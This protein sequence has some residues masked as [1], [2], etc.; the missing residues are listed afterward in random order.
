MGCWSTWENESPSACCI[1]DDAANNECYLFDSNICADLG[2]T[3]YQGQI[4]S[5]TEC[6]IGTTN[7][8]QACCIPFGNPDNEYQTYECVSLTDDDCTQYGGT[9][10]GI[11]TCQ[12]D[13]CE[14]FEENYEA[15]I[16]EP[17]DSL[18]QGACCYSGDAGCGVLSELECLSVDGN[19][20]MGD[21]VAC[22]DVACDD[23]T[24]GGGGDDDGDG[25][26]GS[27]DD[28]DDSDDDNGD[29]SA[30]GIGACC[31]WEEAR[32]GQWTWGCYEYTQPECWE[33][34]GIYKGDDTTCYDLNDNP[35]ANQQNDECVC[36]LLEAI[37]ENNQKILI[38]LSDQGVAI[39][40]SLEVLQMIESNTD[41]LEEQLNVSNTYL[42]KLAMEDVPAIIDILEE[43]LA[44]ND[45]TELEGTTS[46]DVLQAQ[47]ENNMSD[48]QDKL[49]FLYDVE[50]DGD[51]FG[52]SDLQD[53]FPD[54]N[55]L[56]APILTIDSSDFGIELLSGHYVE[57]PQDFSF[58]ASILEDMFLRQLMHAICLL[59][60]T[61]WAALKIF[62]ECRR[63]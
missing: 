48:M 9:W 58:D 31:I 16:C 27:G 2:G 22:A 50:K 42:S 51:I 11:P 60:I 49:S 15:I 20:Y 54:T 13:T 17:E 38:E 26:D 41:N 33:A 32:P 34:D 5:E 39:W 7:G 3:F 10:L 55:N 52:F 44:V 61:W 37:L 46:S 18:P 8:H 6:P 21:D 28:G 59:A 36:L 45:P 30:G 63:Y 12:E 23:E 29:D 40:Q 53:V 47:Y 56:G 4:C 25:G 19:V 1:N 14:S 43:Y 35:C 24:D 57:V 62:E